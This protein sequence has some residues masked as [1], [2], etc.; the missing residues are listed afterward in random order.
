MTENQQICHK[1]LK[2]RTH[3]VRYVA[4]ADQSDSPQHKM[5]PERV[6]VVVV[7]TGKSMTDDRRCTS[8]E[9][10][11]L[12]LIYSWNRRLERAHIRKDLSRVQAGCQSSPHRR[13]SVHRGRLERRQ[14]LPKSVCPDQVW[15]IRV[16]VLSHAP[17]GHHNGRIYLWRDNQH[18][19]ERVCP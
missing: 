11:G 7:G 17:R 4:T 15:A 10:E 18:L 14:D 1:R 12:T 16:F 13:A 9:L 2:R 6:D 19:L 5:A 8:S 3:Y